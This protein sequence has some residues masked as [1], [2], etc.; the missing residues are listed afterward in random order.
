MSPEIPTPDIDWYLNVSREQGVTPRC[1]FATVEACPRYF[2]SLAMLGQAGSTKI[3]PEE[4]KR[5]DALWAKSDLLPRTA[6]H[7]TSILGSDGNLKIFSNFCPEVIYEHFNLFASGLGDYADS[8][9]REAAHERLARSDTSGSN[10]RWRWAWTKPMH[11]TECP[12][13]SV[14]S[15][16]RKTGDE[17]SATGT[18]KGVGPST[19]LVSL[20]PGIG[21]ISVNL[22][23][24]F[25]R[26]RDWW[27]RRS[28]R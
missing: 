4:E 11:F 16:R 14:L 24:G 25:R 10:W 18:G 22:N 20:R 6:E 23:E 27:R 5:L 17:G 3:D 21:G 13:Y 8:I 28:W 9:D 1:P 7:D 19:E 15:H 12:L 26:V 2:D